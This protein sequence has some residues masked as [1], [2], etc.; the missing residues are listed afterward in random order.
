MSTP[1][2]MKMRVLARYDIISQKLRESCVEIHPNTIHADKL[3]QRGLGLAPELFL[4]ID[5]RT[6]FR[7]D[8]RYIR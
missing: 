4:F 6:E 2:M 8:Q 7:V 3:S 1:T 5:V